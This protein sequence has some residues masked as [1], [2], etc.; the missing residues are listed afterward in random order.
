MNN[1]II[2]SILAMIAAFYG[3]YLILTGEVI[4]G[5]TLSNLSLVMSAHL[6]LDDILEKLN[7]E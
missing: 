7:N 2:L 1:K 4:H 5:L 3:V 6:K